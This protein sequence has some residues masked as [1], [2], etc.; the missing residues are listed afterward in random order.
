M[1]AETYPA[2]AAAGMI[3]PISDLDLA[4][5]LAAFLWRSI[6]DDELLEVAERGRCDIRP[7]WRNRRADAGRPRAR[8]WMSDFVG[9]W[10][11]VRNLESIVP[12]P[13]TF[14]E[15]DET[16]RR[17]CSPRRAVL[18]EPGGGRPQHPGPPQGRLHLPKCPA[19]RALRHFDV[20]GSHFRRVP[21]VNPARQGL[22][23]HGSVLTVTSYADRTSVV[24]AR[25]WV[26]ETLLAPLRPR[27]PR[28]FPATRERR[29]RRADVVAG[30]DGAASRQSR[31][32]NL[33]RQSR[34]ARVRGRELRRHRQ[35]ARR[36][37]RRT[38]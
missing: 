28:T 7:S 23:G 19:R 13:L 33:P 27:L 15:F 26:L 12:D 37:Q 36:R 17:R 6:P 21:V 9:Q 29:A 11:Q 4:S 18:R 8:R 5:R 32:R 3:Y 1:R 38:D 20:Y 14:Q 24:L 10:L 2:D 16:L 30:K 22:L 25:K 34:S 31:V 35:V